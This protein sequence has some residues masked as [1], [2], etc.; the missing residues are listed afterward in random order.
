[1]AWGQ[2]EL[3]GRKAE[4]VSDA[5]DDIWQQIHGGVEIVSKDT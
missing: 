3:V 1:V 4:Q 5:L 2:P